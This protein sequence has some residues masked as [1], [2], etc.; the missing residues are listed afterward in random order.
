MVRAHR[1]DADRLLELM[2]GLRAA[3]AAG[4]LSGLDRALRTLADYFS[5]KVYEG[6]PRHL[7]AEPLPVMMDVREALV[8]RIS[9]L[10][11]ALAGYPIILGLDGYDPADL[12]ETIAEALLDEAIGPWYDEVRSRRGAESAN[13]SSP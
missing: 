7:S 5:D 13:L 3:H 11:P 2:A 1:A 6:E 4:T 8:E 12:L 10:A 9:A